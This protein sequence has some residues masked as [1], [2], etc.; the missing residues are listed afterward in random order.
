MADV[1]GI[2]GFALHAAHQIYNVIGLIKDAPSDVQALRDDAFQVF[3]FLKKVVDSQ[4]DGESGY[5][6]VKD[7]EDPQIDALVQKAKAITTAADT[8][9]K[10]T[11]T[12]KDDG[13]YVVKR[14]RWPLYAGEAKKLSD[15]FKSFYASLTAAYTVSTSC[16]FR[17][18]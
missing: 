12:R 5:F 14:I 11:T 16:V 3:C 6:R 2:L 1:L 4:E 8:F 18:A 7:A 17:L 13:T 10:K 9:F 15:Q